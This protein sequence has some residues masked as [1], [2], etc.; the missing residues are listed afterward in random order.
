M[1]GRASGSESGLVLVPQNPP[2]STLTLPE[3]VPNWSEGSAG[4]VKSDDEMPPIITS[5]MGEKMGREVSREEGEEKSKTLF[6]VGLVLLTRGE[7]RALAFRRRTRKRKEGTENDIGESNQI[8]GLAEG[9]SGRDEA[10]ARE[11]QLR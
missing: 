5:L 9:F 1:G 11:G 3:K 10:S 7:E 4:S 2:P 6:R 8:G